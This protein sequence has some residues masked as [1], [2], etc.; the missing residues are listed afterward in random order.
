[1]GDRSHA[2]GMAVHKALMSPK[3]AG[4]LLTGGASQRMGFDKASLSIE[5]IPSAERLAR[6]L[7]QVVTPVIEVG[8]GCS[9]LPA[10]LEEPP[11]AG[12]LVATVAGATALRDAGH[13]GSSLV[14]ACDLPL[15][16][17]TALRLLAGWPG[18]RSV[19]PIVDGYPQPLCARWSAED[20]AVAGDLVD[21]GERSMRTLLARPGVVLVDEAAW[22]S[23]VDADAFADVDS[24]ADLERLGLRWRPSTA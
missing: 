23:T 12:P 16:D 17:E 2:G 10:V 8:P 19:V 6:L 9:G 11:G 15:I 4:M 18:G 22:S 20:L 14:L 1:M 5:G 24:P 21:A 7:C 3:V 13:L